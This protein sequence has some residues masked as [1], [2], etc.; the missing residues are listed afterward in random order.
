MNLIPSRIVLNLMAMFEL[1]V[2][3]VVFMWVSQILD[4]LAL[5]SHDLMIRNIEL[6]PPS[7]ICPFISLSGWIISLEGKGGGGAK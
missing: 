6:S 2:H 1:I 4:N 7:Y 5:M 3:T